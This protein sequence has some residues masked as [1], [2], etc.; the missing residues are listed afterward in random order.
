M[1]TTEMSYYVVAILQW[2][3]RQ[4]G[5]QTDRHT[6]TQQKRVK[7][8]ITLTYDRLGTVDDRFSQ[9]SLETQQ[10]GG[11]LGFSVPHLFWYLWYRTVKT[12]RH[13][14]SL[15][16]E[17]L[18]CLEKYK[19]NSVQSLWSVL[20][21]GSPKPLNSPSK[22]LGHFK[23]TCSILISNYLFTCPRKITIHIT[24]DLSGPM[25]E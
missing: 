23:Y 15:A 22:V 21:L 9:L 14:S 25:F 24:S 6:H 1:L 13:G 12:P 18:H 3:V 7:K 5:R 10:I 8:I 19:G 17:L 2:L 16:Q 11:W 20:R 4:T